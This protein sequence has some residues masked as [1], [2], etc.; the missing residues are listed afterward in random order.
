[1]HLGFQQERIA[2]EK[3]AIFK[4]IVAVNCP[5]VMKTPITDQEA[6]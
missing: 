2:K 1:M 5:Q 3:E 6:Q 4:E